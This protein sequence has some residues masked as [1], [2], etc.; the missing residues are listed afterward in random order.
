MSIVISISN[1]KGGTAKTSTSTNLSLGLAMKGHSTLLIDIDPQGNSTTAVGKDKKSF[2]KTI[3]HCLAKDEAIENIIVHTD[4]KNLD[5]CPSNR[6]LIIAEAELLT[7]IGREHILKRELAKIQ[8]KYS[9][10]IIDCPPS[11]GVLS[12]NALTASNSVIITIEAS[13]F[14]LSGMEEFMTSF[15]LIKYINNDLTVEGILITRAESNTNTFKNCYSQLKQLFGDKC[16]DFCIPR[17]QAIADAQSKINFDDGI[18]KPAIY[19]YPS[20]KGSLMYN[21][22][23]DEVI[24]NVR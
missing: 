4:F 18:A 11:L 6:D 2:D 8:N 22:L 15:Q 5:L 3:Y 14:S 24:N 17:N 13:D 23:V 10:I 16:Y 7:K 21:K 9:Y 1:Q 20:A 19:S 12:T